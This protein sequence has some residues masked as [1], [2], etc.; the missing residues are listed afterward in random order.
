MTALL[1]AALLGASITWDYSGKDVNGEP[2][3]VVASECAIADL[4]GSNEQW[5]PDGDLQSMF[6]EPASTSPSGCGWTRFKD[7]QMKG[8]RHETRKRKRRRRHRRMLDECHQFLHEEGSILERPSRL[9]FSDCA[10][11]VHHA[12]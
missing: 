3:T 8:Q 4:G 1:A 6:G 5:L 7:S 2:E 11:A 12:E 9:R 10:S